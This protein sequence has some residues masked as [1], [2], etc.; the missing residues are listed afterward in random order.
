MGRSRAGR[1]SGSA[2]HGSSRRPRWLDS[3]AAAVVIGIATAACSRA[4]G[5]TSVPIVGVRTSPTAAAAEPSASPSVAQ[6]ICLEDRQPASGTHTVGSLVRHIGAGR[7]LF[8]IEGAGGTEGGTFGLGIIDAAGLRTVPTDDRT[9]AHATWAPGGGIVFDSSRADDRHLFRIADDGSGV[10]QLSSQFRRAEQVAAFGPGNRLAYAHYACDEPKE[11]GLQLAAAD[12]T[13]PVGLTP[14]REVGDPISEGDPTISPDGK[15]VVFVRWTDFDQTNGALWA[16]ST[17]GGEA[18]RLTPDAHAVGYPRFSPDGKSILF[19]QGDTAG[20]TA[21]WLE[22]A[23][24]G[25]AKELTMPPSG[26]FNFESDWSP[27]GSQ[28]VFK[29]Y[30]GSWDHNELHVMAA[31]GSGDTTIWVGDHSTAETPDWGP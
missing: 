18:R 31:D 16:I 25:P 28:I 8:G 2:V 14:P 3:I 9:M 5:P 23:S 12:G 1:H 4:A 6:S 7:I 24:G 15:S 11:L 29:V 30:V 20:Q 13:H 27:D 19:T 22:P 10:T 17:A 21:L 26:S